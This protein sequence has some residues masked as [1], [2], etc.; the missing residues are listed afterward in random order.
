MSYFSKLFSEIWRDYV[1][2]GVP[3]SG[4][5]DPVKGDIRNWGAVVEEHL[6]QVLAAS[7]VAVSHTVSTTE[8]ALAT[9]QIPANTLGANG[10][11]RVTT[12]WTITNSAND[13]TLRARLAGLVG[14]AYLEV[15]LTTQ[16]SY[17]DQRQIANRNAANSQI[18]GSFSA[19]GGF[20]NSGNANVTSA[21]DTTANQDLVI[22]GQLETGSETITLE[23]YLVEVLKRA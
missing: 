9:I 18:G 16:A 17:R 11:L 1:T 20:G 15:V 19:L 6:W 7:A 23:A 10:I 14:T 12:L 22:S 5:H 3:A 2:A 8:T 4:A 13:K 21:V